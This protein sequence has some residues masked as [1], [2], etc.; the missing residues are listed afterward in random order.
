MAFTLVT[1]TG[2]FIRPDQTAASGTATFTLTKAIQNGTAEV[3]PSPIVGVL[4]QTGQLVSQSL[5]PLV[6]VANDDTATVPA[7]SAYEVQLEIDGAPLEPFEIVIP[8]TAAAGTI[9]LST[10]RPVLP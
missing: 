4:S 8:H 7:G 10:L 5:T 6:L 1:L 2:T 9:D 3:Q